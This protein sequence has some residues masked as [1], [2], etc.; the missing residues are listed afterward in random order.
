MFHAHLPNVCISPPPSYVP[1]PPS[2]PVSITKHEPLPKTHPAMWGNEKK[3]QALRTHM[4]QARKRPRPGGEENSRS[5]STGDGV[6]AAGAGR[7]EAAWTTA[8]ATS[9]RDPSRRGEGVSGVEGE[10]ELMPPARYYTSTQPDIEDSGGGARGAMGWPAAPDGVGGSKGRVGRGSMPPPL[11][12][13]EELAPTYHV[14]GGASKPSG[15]AAANGQAGADGGG[16]VNGTAAGGG[17]AVL[18]CP[19]YRRACKMRAPCCQKLFTCR[20]CHD[21]ASDHTVDRGEVKEMLC[22]RC[23]TLQPMHRCVCVVLLCVL[24]LVFAVSCSQIVFISSFCV[25]G[26]ARCV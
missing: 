11:F 13:K 22:M 6:S 23:E 1:R 17:A 18:G 19:H 21:Q 15:G 7:R 3:M 20:L 25:E 8:A 9:G 26:S 4:Y 12:T 10:Q 14:V 24:P 2:P 5:C 16:G